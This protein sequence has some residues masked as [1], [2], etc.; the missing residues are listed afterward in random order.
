MKTAALDNPFTP[1]LLA[2]LG[3]QGGAAAAAPR[4]ATVTTSASLEAEPVC[5]RSEAFAED[6]SDLFPAVAAMAVAAPRRPLLR[7]AL[8]AVLRR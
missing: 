8:A 2:S 3:L 7:R 1:D 5:W 6:L 4:A